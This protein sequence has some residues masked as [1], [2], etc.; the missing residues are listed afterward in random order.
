MVHQLTAEERDAGAGP[1]WFW[2]LADGCGRVELTSGAT[3]PAGHLRLVCQTVL[4]RDQDGVVRQV[5]RDLCGRVEALAN[6]DRVGAACVPQLISNGG[7]HSGA[8][9]IEGPS[10]D[11]ETGVCLLYPSGDCYVQGA[12]PMDELIAQDAYCSCRCDAG[13]GPGPEC[14][15]PDGFSCVEI[16]SSGPADLAGGYCARVE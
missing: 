2:S 8:P 5:D 1:G 9:S 10:P 4:A 13:G 16:L 3:L 12:C 15:C 14:D 7:F 6:D 11:C